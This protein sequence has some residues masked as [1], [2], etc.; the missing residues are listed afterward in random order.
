MVF[1]FGGWGGIV[2]GCNFCNFYFIY[3][4]IVCEFLSI[5]VFFC[6]C[7]VVGFFSI[8]VVNFC[9]C[10]F[11]LSFVWVGVGFFG[12]LINLVVVV[13]LFV[14]VVVVVCVLCSRVGVFLLLGCCW[15]VVVFLCVLFIYLF[16]YL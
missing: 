7:F 8:I 3:F 5:S 6:F 13:V 10:Y 2:F 15:L 11:A 1:F 16:I 9:C 14:V 12:V 4:I